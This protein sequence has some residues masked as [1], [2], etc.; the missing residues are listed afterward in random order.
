MM[1]VRR[2]EMAAVRAPKRPAA[3]R[4]VEPPKPKLRVVPTV[5]TRRRRASVLGLLGCMLV[6]G[7]LIGLTAFQAQLAQNQIEVDQVA[8]DLRTEQLKFDHARLQ[9]AQMQAPEV[10]LAKAKKMGMRAPRP[11]EQPSYLPPSKDTVTDV[12]IANGGGPDAQVKS[13][14]STRPDWAAYKKI[15][16]EK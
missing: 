3:S 5:R 9:I 1:N 15:T 11:G 4:P 16:G 13:E 2:Q 14:S 12:M 6:F 8:R 7:F 10:I